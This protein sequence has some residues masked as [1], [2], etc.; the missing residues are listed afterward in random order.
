M[1]QEPGKLQIVNYRVAIISSVI[2]VL[3]TIFNWYRNQY[4]NMEISTPMYIY[5]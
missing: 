2:V 5:I 1:K 3:N 4:A